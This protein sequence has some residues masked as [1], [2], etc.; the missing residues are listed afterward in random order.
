MRLEEWM[1][2]TDIDEEGQSVVLTS[3]D[4]LMAR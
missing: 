2:T 4:E 3:V 1:Q